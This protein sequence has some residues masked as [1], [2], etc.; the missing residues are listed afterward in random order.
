[1]TDCVEIYIGRKLVVT[2]N[3]SI[4]PLVGCKISISKVTYKVVEV[5]YAVDYADDS[6]RARMVAAVVVA[7]V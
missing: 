5:T 7:R 2:L 3:S 1:M 6:W 4:V